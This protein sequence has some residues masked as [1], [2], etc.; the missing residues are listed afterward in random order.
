M[1][2]A[3]REDARRFSIESAA[4]GYAAVAESL[5]RTKPASGTAVC[6]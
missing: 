5:A 2:E 1:A 6:E 3:N 4:A